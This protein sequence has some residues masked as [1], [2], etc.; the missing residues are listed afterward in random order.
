MKYIVHKRFKEKAICG[1]VNIPALTECEAINGMIYFN[2]KPICLITSE[3]A[4]LYFA[5]ND[6]RNGMQRGKL[7][8]DIISKL[9]TRDNNYQERWNKIWDDAVCQ[10]YKRHEYSDHWLW[11]HAFYNADINTLLY[12][13]KLIEVRR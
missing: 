11:N 1:N 7:T 2:H 8:S 3:N 5:R 13:A 10:A 4:H 9:K 12:I 6:D